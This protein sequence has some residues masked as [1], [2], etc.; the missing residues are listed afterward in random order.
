MTYIIKNI[1]SRLFNQSLFSRS[2]GAVLL[3]FALL[4][5]GTGSAW[6]DIA[7]DFEI[8]LT[9][10]PVGDLPTGVTKI[11]Y[12]DPYEASY[13]GTQH[14][15]C[16]YAIEFEV[17]CA[18]DITLGCCQ[19][20][21]AGYEAYLVGEDGDMI[22]TIDN[23]TPGCDGT[24]TYKYRGEG[25]KLILYCGQYCPSIKVSKAV[26]ATD[27]EIDLTK[28]F[29]LPSGVAKIV[30]SRGGAYNHGDSHGWCWYAI[31]FEVDGPVDVTIGGCNYQ[32]N[33]YGFI[34]DETGKKIADIKNNDC[35][36]T[37]TY[38]YR[39]KGTVMRLYCGQYRRTGLAPQS[40][41][42]FSAS[43]REIDQRIGGWWRPGSRTQSGRRK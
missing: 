24:V 38:S 35:N 22:A 11:S 37:F 14:G 4:I 9:K 40:S 12:P 10:N 8:D 29:V 23:K 19:Y 42:L 21:N 17:D 1:Y 2:L 3:T 41:T 27:F 13:N 7:T 28:D 33:Y 36:K 6:A 16:W 30:D 5:G 20:T 32:N 31:E 34:T 26:F 18:V 25:Q 39:R 43:R 15:W